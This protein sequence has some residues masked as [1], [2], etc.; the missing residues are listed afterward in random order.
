MLSNTYIKG[1]RH[2]E[3]SKKKMSI[4]RKGKGLGKK[5]SEETKKKMRGNFGSLSPSAVKVL[6]I[7]KT[8]GEELCC[9]LSI[10]DIF[11]ELNI[12]ISNIPA[13]CRNKRKSAGGFK[14][15]YI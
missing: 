12:S 13:C 10:T 4:A 9:W 2:T 11:R 3:E 15:K 7:N 5:A 14:W 6:Q 1:R 8:T